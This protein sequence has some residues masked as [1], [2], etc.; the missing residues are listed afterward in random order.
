MIDAKLVTRESRLLTQ[1]GISL[2]GEKCS[3]VYAAGGAGSSDDDAGGDDVDGG[4]AGDATGV[5]GDG[6]VRAE[7]AGLASGMKATF[8]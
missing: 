2:V 1:C 7:S 5:G 4:G 6:I 8:R 3:A